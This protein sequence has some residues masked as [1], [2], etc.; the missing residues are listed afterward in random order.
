MDGQHGFQQKMAATTGHPFYPRS[1]VIPGYAPSKHSMMEILFP[2][3]A[4][5]L[6]LI[7]G[8][9]IS[10]YH[11]KHSLTSSS[12]GTKL[13]FVWFLACGCI[14]LFIEGWFSSHA[15]TIA[16]LDDYMSDLWKEYARSDSRYMTFDPF[17][18]LMESV[19]AVFTANIVCLGNLILHDSLVDLF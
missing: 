6:L 4:G 16:G 19:T 3:F 18:F 13:V 7:L 9:L 11:R 5:S 14:H 15:K 12:A 8:G 10:I 1:L 17:V 2:F